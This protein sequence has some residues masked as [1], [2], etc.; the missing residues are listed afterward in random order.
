MT[1]ENQVDSGGVVTD[2]YMVFFHRFA[3]RIFQIFQSNHFFTKI[4]VYF[5]FLRFC[6]IAKICTIRTKMLP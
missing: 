4:V 5:Y 1:S 2:R 6:C 3:R